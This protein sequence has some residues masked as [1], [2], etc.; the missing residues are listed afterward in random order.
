MELETFCRCNTWFDSSSANVLL[1]PGVILDTNVDFIK[2][3]DLVLDT[4]GEERR[5]K[6]STMKKLVKLAPETVR[7][8][9]TFLFSKKTMTFDN[10]DLSEDDHVGLFNF[11]A[12]NAYRSEHET[13]MNV[14]KSKY[15]EFV[16]MLANKNMIIRRLTGTELTFVTGNE[17][18]ET[19][20]IADP[21]SKCDILVCRSKQV[22]A[23]PDE[24]LQK[25]CSHTIIHYGKL[26]RTLP[27][28]TLDACSFT[29]ND[30]SRWLE[31]L[32]EIIRSSG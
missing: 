23:M 17:P 3:Y 21:P 18:S 10:I 22:C 12:R 13:Y 27:L 14:E 5:L 2:D 26:S 31:D 29:S 32:E 8:K 15:E 11:C 7:Y 30:F 9:D 16:A 24:L 28:R 19:L 4:D 6:W 20:V 1:K 25:I